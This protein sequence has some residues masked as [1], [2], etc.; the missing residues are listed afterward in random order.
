MCLKLPGPLLLLGCLSL[1][2]L[3]VP[4]VGTSSE[5]LFSASLPILTLPAGMFDVTTGSH[6]PSLHLFASSHSHALP[7]S[8]T[9]GSSLMTGAASSLTVPLGT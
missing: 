5:D 8:S 9:S 3:I 4:I 2:I 6:L 1:L 7:V